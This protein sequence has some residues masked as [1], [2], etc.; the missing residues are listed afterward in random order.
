MISRLVFP[1]LL[2]SLGCSSLDNCPEGHDGTIV[3]ETGRSNKDALTYESAPW[4]GPLDAF[5]AKSTVTFVHDLGVTPLHVEPMLA[6]TKDGT[7]GAHGGSVAPSAGNQS[8]IDC[9]DSHVIV[10]RNDTC[11]KSFFIRVD[12]FGAGEDRGKQCS[13]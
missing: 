10:V 5:P 4:D 3:I 7:H 2:A 12:A 6:F 1:F 8:L 9:V 11:E 13:E